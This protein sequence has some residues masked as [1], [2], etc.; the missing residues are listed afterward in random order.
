M[1]LSSGKLF[2]LA[3]ASSTC[4]FCNVAGAT[5][6]LDGSGFGSPSAVVNYDPAAAESNFG[7]PGN[8]TDAAAYNIYTKQDA[9]YAYVLV[10][11]N[12][13]GGAAVGTFANLYFGVGATAFAHS[14][15]GTEVTNNDTFSP[16]GGGTFSYTGTGILETA[17]SATSIE[18]A[19][20]FSYFETDPQG[21]GFPTVDAADP[22]IVLRLSQSFGY[23]VA[24]GASYGTDDLGV[25]TDPN[26]V[27][28]PASI[29]LVAVGLTAL[30]ASRRR[31][32]RG[33]VDQAGLLIP[34]PSSPNKTG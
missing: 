14:T 10:A 2:A 9:T 7:T 27:P 16:G 24:G 21:I 19:I 13:G 1:H 22:N 30:F 12:G 4:F 3:L 11:T 18:V 28:E 20:P 29:G 8:V 5:P 17:L 6:V 25:F 23:S 26:F 32:R 15:F 34:R 33:P 31:T